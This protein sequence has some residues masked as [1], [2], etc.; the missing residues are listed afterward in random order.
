MPPSNRQTSL[1]W[2][3][4]TP[5]RSRVPLTPAQERVFEQL[6]LGLSEKEASTRLHISRHTVHNH[7]RAIYRAFGVATRSELLA[8]LLS[9]GPSA[10]KHSAARR[11]A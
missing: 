5:E 10:T 9:H 2:A 3:R 7:I 11:R 6:A 4:T 1:K 8:Y